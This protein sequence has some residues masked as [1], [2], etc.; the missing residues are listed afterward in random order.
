MNTDRE[1]QFIED[2]MEAARTRR[3]SRPFLP[4]TDGD[5]IGALPVERPLRRAGDTAVSSAT[6]L[7]NAMRFGGPMDRDHAATLAIRVQQ[8]LVEPFRGSIGSSLPPSGFGAR[9]EGH[10]ARFRNLTPRGRARSVRSMTWTLAHACLTLAA[11]AVLI[12][13]SVRLAAAL[14]ALRVF[15]SLAHPVPG[16]SA[17]IVDSQACAAPIRDE[18]QVAWRACVIGHMCDLATL[19]AVAAYLMAHDRTAWGAAVGLVAV[20]EVCGTMLRVAAVQGG[21]V[22]RRLLLERVMRNGSLVIALVLASFLQPAVPTTGVPLIALV[23][24]GAGIYAV[25]EITRVLVTARNAGR[26]DAGSSVETM[27]LRRMANLLPVVERGVAA[28]TAEMAPLPSRQR[29]LAS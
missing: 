27:V 20:L 6:V 24:V 13:G 11:A 19:F 17:D 26:V 25:G 9:L 2:L 14:L 23:G 28:D 4:V 3:P 29:R 18:W 7:A 16:T 15:V 8:Q 22:L 21:I 10:F 1:R 5:G 12:T